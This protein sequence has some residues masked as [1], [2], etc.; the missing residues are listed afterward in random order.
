MSGQSPVVLS[1]AGF[2]PGSGAGISADLKTIAAHGC[3]GI[4][5]ITALT[6]QN[7]QGVKKMEPLSG[8]LVRETLEELALDF[9]IAAIR[10][11]MLA[12]AEVAI[13]VADFLE[14]RPGPAVVLDPVLKASSGTVL[15]GEAGVEL[16]KRRL[17]SLVTVVTPNVPEAEELTNLKIESTDGMA[18]AARRLQEMGARNVVVTGGHLPENS[19]VLVEESGGQHVFASE[20]IDSRSTHGTGCAFA[21]AIACNLALGHAL[22]DAVRQAK[23]YV[24]EAIAQAKPLGKGT[25]PINHLYRLE[26]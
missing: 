17:L 24:S 14:R 1:I 25:G 18:T 6:V 8:R 9:P 19:D 13:S 10:I 21:T 23:Q 11:G 12:T 16:L 22:P 15:L 20:R 7:T 4:A 26:K 3:F 5:C 2:D